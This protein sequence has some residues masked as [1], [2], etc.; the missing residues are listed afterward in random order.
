MSEIDYEKNYRLMV[1]MEK[2]HR[3]TIAHKE[4]I[5]AALSVENKMLWRAI[6]EKDKQLAE[7]D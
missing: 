3:E 2:Y 5:N 6:R 7:I 4:S 1:E